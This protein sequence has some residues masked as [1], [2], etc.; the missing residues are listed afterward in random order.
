MNYGKLKYILRVF[1]ELQL[2]E[3][4]EIQSDLYQF[5]IFF[6]ASKTNIEKSSILK[7]LKSQCIDFH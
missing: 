7:K 2:C 3:V 6:H 5:R 4:E 1:N